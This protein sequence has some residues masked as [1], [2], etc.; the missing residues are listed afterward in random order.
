MYRMCDM[1][2]YDRRATKKL[3]NVKRK[4]EIVIEDLESPYS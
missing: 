1:R 2:E 4:Q 3:K